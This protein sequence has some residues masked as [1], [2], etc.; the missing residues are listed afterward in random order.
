MALCFLKF[1]GDMMTNKTISEMEAFEYVLNYDNN[2][3]PDFVL[4]EFKKADMPLELFLYAWQGIYDTEIV[5]TGGN[6]MV[7]V[8][9]LDNGNICTVTDEAIAIYKNLDDFYNYEN[10]I[11][12]AFLNKGE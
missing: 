9:T 6:C 3:N 5:N 12:E 8:I 11:F 10:I 7:T 4:N 1:K 2:E